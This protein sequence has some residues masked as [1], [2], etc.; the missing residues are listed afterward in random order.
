MDRKSIL[1]GFS[2]AL[3][4]VAGV[5]LNAG[6]KGNG[7]NGHVPPGNPCGDGPGQGTGNPCN[8]NNGNDGHQGNAGGRSHGGS[9]Y[10]QPH[11]FSIER[12]GNASGAFITQIGEV[13][14]ASIRQS[15][16]R[17]FADVRQYGERNQ[18]DVA[19]AGSGAHYA[20]VGQLG[21]EN[22]VELGQAGEGVQVAILKQV[23][24]DNRMDVSQT[25]DGASSGVFALQL[26]LDNALSLAQSGSGN[27]AA[28]VQEGSGNEMNAI[29]NGNN[30]LV[31]TQIGDNLSHATI[32]Q[33][34]GQALQI[35]QS[36]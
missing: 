25:G 12:P 27:Q 29:Q 18:A 16:N 6:G 21:A 19:Q 7:G 10:D 9:D 17:Q 23:G 35:T 4:A 30:L 2:V 1:L 15:D 3:I 31:W 14:Q 36:N 5:P 22:R 11:P 8:G 24:H 20:L 13:N 32:D 34:A 26:G 28:L 33:G